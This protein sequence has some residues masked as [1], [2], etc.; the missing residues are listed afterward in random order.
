MSSY[1]AQ[2]GQ[3]PPPAAPFTFVLPAKDQDTRAQLQRKRSREDDDGEYDI[4]PEYRDNYDDHNIHNASPG[5][6]PLSIGDE[7]EF[8][9][10]S[11]VEGM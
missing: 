6:M 5:D 2:N 4:H 3:H 11:P 7:D 9:G 1:S 8:G 10:H